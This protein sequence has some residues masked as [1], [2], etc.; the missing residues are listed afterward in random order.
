VARP[1]RVRPSARNKRRV[2][3]ARSEGG[4]STSGGCTLASVTEEDPPDGGQQFNPNSSSIFFN[5]QVVVASF[6]VS[7]AG[8]V[9]FGNVPG[10]FVYDAPTMSATFTAA[11]PIMGGL[12]G[13][14]TS[15]VVIDQGTP[16]E[17]TIV[18]HWTV[19][20]G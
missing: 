14:A 6:T 7:V 5:Q 8:G 19:E 11:P 4:S 13:N 18:W 3:C 17:Q 12:G 16:C 10:G 20:A 1:H 2:C 15:T 9:P